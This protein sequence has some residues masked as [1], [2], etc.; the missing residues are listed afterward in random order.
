MSTQPP[1]DEDRLGRIE[2]A[3]RKFHTDNP[4]VADKLEKMAAEWF[5]SGHDHVAIKML[6]EALRWQEGIRVAAVD[7]FRLNN[8]YTA[9]YARL[10]IERRPEWASRIKTRELRAA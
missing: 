6:W 9:R 2:A 4:H 7:T 10:L 5:A 3:F 1:T 8:N